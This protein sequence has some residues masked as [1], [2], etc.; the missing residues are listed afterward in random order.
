M[1][2]VVHQKKFSM[3]IWMRVIKEMKEE[4]SSSSLYAMS[5]L[6]T[7]YS[8]SLDNYCSHLAAARFFCAGPSLGFPYYLKFDETN[9]H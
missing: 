9:N 6:Q 5:R 4:I 3:R 8:C 7:E 1:I 2:T